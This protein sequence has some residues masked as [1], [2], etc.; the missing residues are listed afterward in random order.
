[1]SEKR[2]EEKKEAAFCFYVLV[3]SLFSV[4]L[5]IPCIY[6]SVC[7]LNSDRPVFII[8]ELAWRE[9]ERKKRERRERMVD[10]SAS[11][12]LSFSLSPSLPSIYVIVPLFVSLTRSLHTESTKGGNGNGGLA[13]CFFVEKK[14]KRKKGHAK[15]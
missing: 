15:R 7:D 9:E 1:M 10:L 13:V 12:F 8:S 4:Q 2:E 5:H 3:F 6:I 11:L 14:G